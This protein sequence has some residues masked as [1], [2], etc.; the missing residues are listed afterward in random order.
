MHDAQTTA[1]RFGHVEVDGEHLLVA[2]LDQPTGL[3]F[4]LLAAAGADPDRIRASVE[5]ELR[6]RP[7]VPGPGAAPG[8][9]FLTQRLSQL[10]DTAQR[11]AS[12]L[13]HAQVPIPTDTSAGGHFENN[14]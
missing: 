4:R 2:L 1:L 14:V 8:Q 6:R 5:T 9:V 11:K 3:G 10:L 13:Q 12:R 7:R